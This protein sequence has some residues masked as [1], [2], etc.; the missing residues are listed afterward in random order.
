MLGLVGV[1]EIEDSRDVTVRV[2]LPETVPEVAV[3][4]AVPAAMVVTKPLSLTVGTDGFDGV[5]SVSLRSGR[6]DTQVPVKA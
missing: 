2:W 3:M 1:T 6:R 4:V 5:L